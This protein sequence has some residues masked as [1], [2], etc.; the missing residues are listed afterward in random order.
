MEKAENRENKNYGSVP[1][2]PDGVEKIKKK[3]AKN[4]KKQKNTITASFQARLGWKGLRNR[5]NIGYR[6]VSFLHDVLM[7]IPKKQQKN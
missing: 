7:K 3:I 5:E 4:F 1:F 6:S 2:L